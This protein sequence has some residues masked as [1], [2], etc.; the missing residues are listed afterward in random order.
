MALPILLQDDLNHGV[1]FLFRHIKLLLVGTFKSPRAWKLWSGS[2]NYM[3][4]TFRQHTLRSENLGGFV[5]VFPLKNLHAHFATQITRAE[6]K[7]CSGGIYRGIFFGDNNQHTQ[8]NGS[9]ETKNFFFLLL[10]LEY[11]CLE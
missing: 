3:K 5:L 10:K 8:E 9:L 1:L 11:Y 2:I 4:H 6:F 7:K